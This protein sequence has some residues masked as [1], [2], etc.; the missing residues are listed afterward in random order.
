MAVRF[1]VSSKAE[2]E[3]ESDGSPLRV[4]SDRG[5]RET[6]LLCAHGLRSPDVKCASIGDIERIGEQRFAF[7]RDD[8]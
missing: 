1:G 3:N 2:T 6:I 7:E 5:R 4:F 8:M